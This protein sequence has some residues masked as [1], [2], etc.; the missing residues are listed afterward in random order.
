MIKLIVIAD[1]LT[2]SID[3]GVQFAKRGIKT[4]VTNNVE[5]DFSILEQRYEV[6]VVNTESRHVSKTNAIQRIK[7]ISQKIILH[8]VQYVY[9]KTDSTLRGNIGIEIETLLFE[10]NK[11]VIPF[12]P[13]YPKAERYT[14]MGYMYVAENLLEYT[15]FAKDPLNPVTSSFVP[16]ILS[17]QTNIQSKVIEIGNKNFEK[18]GILVFDCELNY[19]LN[20][21]GEL[22]KKNEMLDLV[23]GSAGFAEIL[24]DLI[25]FKEKKI[26]IKQNFNPFLIINGSLTDASFDQCKYAIEKDFIDVKIP[27]SLLY[28]SNPEF[29]SIIEYIKKEATNCVIR[30][31]LS[32]EEF[33]QYSSSFP[34]LDNQQKCKYG[35]T[36]LGK[37]AFELINQNIYTNVVIFGG[38]TSMAVIQMLNSNGLI[39]IDEIVPGMA[40]VKIDGVYDEL[41]IIT[42]S[43][44]FGEISIIDNV[45]NKLT[46]K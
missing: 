1:D 14:S 9:K 11:K 27:S 5:L 32:H 16:E 31:V 34:K 41:N 30:T 40:L 15:G 42:K 45:I 24:P 17:T 33:D 12:I 21:I 39:P 36:N 20:T 18:E 2:G 6:L 37:I 3:T 19:D 35:A 44:G 10:L 22:L 8:Q 25:H 46:G 7:N 26:S 4:Y 29:H 38:D 23:A 13:A 43:G 28:N